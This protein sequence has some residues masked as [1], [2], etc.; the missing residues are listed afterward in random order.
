VEGISILLWLSCAVMTLMPMKDRLI[1]TKTATRHLSKASVYDS[2]NK[3][4]LLR[5]RA[6]YMHALDGARRKTRY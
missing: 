3:Q 1:C 6:M 4:Q 5:A 2:G